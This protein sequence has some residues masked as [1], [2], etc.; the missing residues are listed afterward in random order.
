MRMDLSRKRCVPCEGGAKPMAEREARKYLRMTEGWRLK[1][2]S[3]YRDMEFKDFAAAMRFVDKVAAAAEREGHH[4]DIYLHSW[5]RL[6]L[7]LST[8]AIGGLSINDFVLA[9]KINRIR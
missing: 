5:N 8:H 4:P 1:N 2:S 7:T 6:R 3:I 9:S